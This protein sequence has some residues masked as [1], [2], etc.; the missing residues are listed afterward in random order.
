MLPNILQCTGWPLLT[1]NYLAPN[2]HS[3]EPGNPGTDCS[4]RKNGRSRVGRGPAASRAKGGHAKCAKTLT[5]DPQG[6]RALGGQRRQSGNH[7]GGRTR[8]HSSRTR[9]EEQAHALVPPMHEPIP[10]SSSCCGIRGEGLWA[11]VG[12]GKAPVVDLACTQCIGQ[13]RR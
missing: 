6:L 10:A 13:T 8:S 2:V 1:K 9:G 7:G 3:A 4:W 12:S 5:G 11:A